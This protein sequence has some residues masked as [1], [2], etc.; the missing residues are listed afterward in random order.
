M[1]ELEHGSY[2]GWQQHQKQ[3]VP[4]TPECGCD[5]ARNAYMAG[6]RA[7]HPEVRERARAHDRH[8]SRALSRLALLHPTEYKALLAEEQQRDES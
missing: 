2:G 7:R 8:R 1:V 6:Y 4:T 3:G 5:A